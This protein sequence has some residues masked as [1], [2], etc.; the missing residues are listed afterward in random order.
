MD[1]KDKLIIDELRR[2]ARAP[3]KDIAKST[4]IRP[5]TVHQRIQRLLREGTI[6]KFTIKTSDDA[7]GESFAA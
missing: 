2:D 5:S 3:I 6:E 7:V 1:A 4:G